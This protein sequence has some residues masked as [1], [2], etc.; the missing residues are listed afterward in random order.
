MK[1]TC[2]CTEEIGLVYMSIWFLL[3]LVQLHCCWK[4]DRIFK[5]ARALKEKRSCMVL[6]YAAMGKD[7]LI[8]TAWN[9]ANTSS[10]ILILL[11]TCLVIE[12]EKTVLHHLPLPKL[13]P[14]ATPKYHKRHL[15]LQ[16]CR[17]S[18]EQ[19]CAGLWKL[20]K[21]SWRLSVLPY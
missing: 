4:Q 15:L 3:A 2:K 9:R 1:K 6:W 13:W 18:R 14:R 11:S 10:S 5:R 7:W 12:W 20:W 21:W 17:G 16:S 8:A 19:P